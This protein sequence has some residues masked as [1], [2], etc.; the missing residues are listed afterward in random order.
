MSVPFLYHLHEEPFDYYRYTPYALK[1]LAQ[2]AGL[3]M[4]SIQHYGSA[5][6]M[7][8]DITSKIGQSLVDGLCKL[9]PKCISAGIRSVVHQILR[10]FQ[11]LCFLLLKQGWVLKMLDRLN[12]SY[13]TALGYIAVFT[14]RRT[15]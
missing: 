13:R 6:G 8:V 12:L 15:I 5:F 2:N 7:L 1:H 4:I 3:E 11:Q 9:L 10:G 14:V